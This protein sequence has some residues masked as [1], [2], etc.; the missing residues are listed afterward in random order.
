[1]KDLEIECFKYVWKPEIDGKKGC[2]VCS[3]RNFRDDCPIDCNKDGAYHTM[4]EFERFAERTMQRIREGK[5][6]LEIDDKMK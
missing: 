3:L 2:S 1:M 4:N 5:L 6:K